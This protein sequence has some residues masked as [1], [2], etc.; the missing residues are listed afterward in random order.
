MRSGVE[1]DTGSGEVS[2]ASGQGLV[3]FRIWQ[4]YRNYLI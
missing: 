4:C 1:P 3:A 2:P